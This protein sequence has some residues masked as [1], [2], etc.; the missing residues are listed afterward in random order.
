MLLDLG[1]VIWK[2][3]YISVRTWSNP[4]EFV[5]VPYSWNPRAD[6]YLTASASSSGSAC[7]IGAYEWLDFTIGS[8]TRGSVRN[9]A[10]LVEVYGIRPSHRSMDLTGVVP[11]SEEMDTAGFFARD[12]QLFYEIASEWLVWTSIIV[13]LA[14][15]SHC[16]YVDSSV[17]K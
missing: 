1:A 9:P 16:R 2:N 4:W 10:A 6:G 3:S 11:V 15:Q 8:D 12:P 13:L 7:T 5:D 17:A 14:Y